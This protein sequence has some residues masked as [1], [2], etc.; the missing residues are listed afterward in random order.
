MLLS[1]LLIGL[2][3]GM[4][5][6][7]MCGPLQA[8]IFKKQR[9]SLAVLLFHI[10]RILTYVMIGIIFYLFGKGISFVGLQEI[11][12]YLICIYIFYFY[13]IPKKWKTFKF[14][15]KIE[16]APFNFFKKLLHKAPKNNKNLM[17]FLTGIL[18]GLLPCGLVYM[19]AA[20]SLL[21]PNLAYNI[22][23][24]SL[25]GLSTL[26]WLLGSTFLIKLPLKFFKNKFVRLKPILA[27][28]II[29]VL[30]LRTTDIS[31][32]Q[33]PN[34]ATQ[35]NTTIPICGSSTGIIR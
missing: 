21:A 31:M 13:V 32:L 7:L 14:L 23:G 8:S 19:A 34:E 3:G 18:N 11:F 33:H 16:I 17:R 26:P 27:V 15:E 9:L 28:A 30:L 1:S 25:F 6:G 5:C 10:G 4:H 35:S 29:F 20:N 22:L 2:A 12:I 24:M